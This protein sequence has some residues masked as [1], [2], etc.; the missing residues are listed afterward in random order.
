MFS[1]SQ[2]IIIGLVGSIY[3]AGAAFLLTGYSFLQDRSLPSVDANK[4]RGNGTRAAENPPYFFPVLEN[5]ILEPEDPTN[6]LSPAG[7]EQTR[8]SPRALSPDHQ[9]IGSRTQKVEL[10]LLTDPVCLN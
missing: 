1:L 3:V 5:R 8:T 2:Y 10:V 4:E 7:E 6:S 9:T